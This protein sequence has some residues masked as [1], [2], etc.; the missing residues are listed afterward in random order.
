MT[1]IIHRKLSTAI[2]PSVATTQAQAFLLF[3]IRNIW[4]TTAASAMTE[5]PMDST[6][7]RR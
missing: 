5:S 2:G 3:A 6:P 4:M 7:T 1:S